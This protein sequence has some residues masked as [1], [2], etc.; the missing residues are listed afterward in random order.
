MVSGV[1]EEHSVERAVLA[2][3][4]PSKQCPYLEGVDLVPRGNTSR[5]SRENMTHLCMRSRVDV[6]F[7]NAIDQSYEQPEPLELCGQHQQKK[8]Y[9]RAGCGGTTRTTL[10]S[11]D[12]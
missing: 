2:G 11:V 3:H 12:T 4:S 6:L 1:R 8:L 10:V 7:G 9:C 5:R